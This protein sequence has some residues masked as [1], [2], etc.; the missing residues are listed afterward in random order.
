MRHDGSNSRFALTIQLVFR[1]STDICR[2]TPLTATYCL[3]CPSVGF[4]HS[5]TSAGGDSC[6]AALSKD[7]VTTVQAG[8]QAHDPHSLKAVIITQAYDCDKP[9]M[10]N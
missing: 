5:V 3:P 10:C 4:I 1:S 8:V 6:G 9:Q 7:L 2:S